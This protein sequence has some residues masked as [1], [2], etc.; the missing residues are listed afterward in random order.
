M[1]NKVYDR[2]GPVWAASGPIGRRALA[3]RENAGAVTHLTGAKRSA[4][5]QICV[6][7]RN[8]SD[9]NREP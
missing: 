2:G 6:R 1:E 8:F 4:L 9:A 3:A 7:G 5:P